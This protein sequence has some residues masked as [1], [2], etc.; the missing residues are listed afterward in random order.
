M[1]P[2]ID[3]HAHSLASNFLAAGEADFF[4]FLSE[5]QHLQ[6]R[7]E[8]RLSLNGMLFEKALLQHAGVDNLSAYLAYRH[9]LGLA[10]VSRLFADVCI[11]AVLLDYGFGHN[12]LSLD[13]FALA[14]GVK[15]FGIL[16]L[17]SLF[18]ELL[19]QYDQPGTLES[20]LER[21]LAESGCVALKTIC[22][23][24]GGLSLLSQLTEENSQPE[25]EVDEDES[26]QKCRRQVLKS[27]RIE[28]R[29][30]Y[31][32]LL[33]LSF[34]LA[35]RR[36]LPVQVHSGLGDDDALLQDAN[37]LLAQSLFRRNNINGEPLPA[38]VLLH[39]YPFHKEAA[40]LSSIYEKVYFDLSLVN[41]LSAPS[42]SS[43]FQEALALAPYRKMLTG[44]DGHSQPESFWW[45]A[46]ST[47]QALASLY[48]CCKEDGLPISSEAIEKVERSIFYDNALRLYNLDLP[49]L[50]ET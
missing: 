42:F 48:R 3:N 27:G 23:Y 15:V 12:L 47:R 41:F 28:G 13:D 10:S 16:R 34:H 45:A 4:S 38:F 35:A 40:Y 33:A 31:L 25:T 37:P 9:K 18:E 11:K 21:H 14:A 20:A 39:C 30:Y 43:I 46:G 24:R 22:A 7:S 8:M 26:F 2:I 50:P 36:G 1:L 19:R 5:S 17:E 44:T 32:R 29:G 49:P 6:F